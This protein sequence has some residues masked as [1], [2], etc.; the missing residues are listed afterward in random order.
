MSELIDLATY[1]AKR[2]KP[3]RYMLRVVFQF[4]NEIAFDDMTAML[5]TLRSIGRADIADE[6]FERAIVVTP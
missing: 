6:I 4:D 2:V 5:D 1:R 3:E